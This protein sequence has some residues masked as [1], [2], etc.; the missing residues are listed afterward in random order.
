MEVDIK[1]L[2]LKEG[3]K[4]ADFGSGSGFYTIEAAKRVTG[5]GQV[6]AIDVQKDLLS[7]IQSHARDM[8]LHNVQ[9]VWGDIDKIGGSKLKDA[10]VDAVI[11]SNVLFQSEHKENLAKEAFRILKQGGEVMLIDWTDSF[12][13]MG[14][15]KSQIVGEVAATSIFEKIGFKTVKNFYAGDH[16][17]GVIM[18]K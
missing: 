1:N 10:M 6:F 9:V 16:H 15:A 14:P 13:G 17:W 18:K 11:V 4:V 2:D 8:G 12:G 7:K 5:N 3:I